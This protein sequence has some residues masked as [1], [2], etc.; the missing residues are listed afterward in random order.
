M[1]VSAPAIA[2]PLLQALAADRRPALPLPEIER[3]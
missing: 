2:A 1:E 3:I